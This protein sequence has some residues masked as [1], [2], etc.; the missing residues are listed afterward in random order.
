MLYTNKFSVYVG[1]S[2]VNKVMLSGDFVDA[3]AAAG[4]HRYAWPA[5]V[6]VGMGPYPST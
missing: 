5:I 6:A 2:C 4:K 3:G 1:S